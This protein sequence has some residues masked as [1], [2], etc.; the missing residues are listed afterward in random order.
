[1]CNSFTYLIK[2][3]CTHGRVAK[4]IW[5]WISEIVGLQI[6]NSFRVVAT[7]G[8]VNMCSSTGYPVEYIENC[9]K[10]VFYSKLPPFLNAPSLPPHL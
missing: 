8:F 10:M 7:K 4:V 1:M 5:Y 2:K 6:G 9:T 3:R